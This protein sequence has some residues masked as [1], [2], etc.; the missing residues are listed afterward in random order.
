MNGTTDEPSYASCFAT[1][2]NMV[3]L[4]ILMLVLVVSGGPFRAFCRATVLRMR[5]AVT[6]VIR[7]IRQGAHDAVL[8][9]TA[10]LRCY[11]EVMLIAVKWTGPFRRALRRRLLAS[12]ARWLPVEQEGPLEDIVYT[13]L[14]QLQVARWGGCRRWRS[15]RARARIVFNPQ[16]HGQ[17]MFQALRYV[18]GLHGLAKPSLASLRAQT[19]L[20]LQL[21]WQRDERIS[22]R[23]L[24]EWAGA[25]GQTVSY[26]IKSVSTRCPRWGNTLDLLLLARAYQLPLLVLDKKGK[27]LLRHGPLSEVRATII[28]HQQ[29][30]FVVAGKRRHRAATT[31]ETAVKCRV[32]GAMNSPFTATEY[33]DF[34]DDMREDDGRECIVKE[35]K[36]VPVDM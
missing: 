31:G 12:R 30:F 21:A 20:E 5:V 29:H 7:G 36:C 35:D 3:Q 15:P 6:A 8:I 13:P 9:R 10:F 17:C 22:G 18:M 2:E 16:T 11:F 19:R 23:S 4:A 1:L 25:L 28:W 14:Q 24:N 27:V 34:L 32:G 26:L 33:Y